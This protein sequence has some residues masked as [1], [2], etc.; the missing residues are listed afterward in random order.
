MILRDVADKTIVWIN[1][2]KSMGTMISQCDPVHLAIPWGP[3][4]YLMEVWSSPFFRDVVYLTISQLAAKDTDKYG[5]MIVGIEIVTNLLGRCAIYE[6][7]YPG[8]TRVKAEL[9]SLYAKILT[10][11]ITAKRFY[12]VNTAG[13][14]YPDSPTVGVRAK[15]L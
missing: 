13:M 6:E 11:L 1:K 8:S 12:S 5:S 15:Q 4:K 2:F 14:I 9:V 7:L 10:Y 3:I